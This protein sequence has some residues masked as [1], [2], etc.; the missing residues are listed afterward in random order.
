MKNLFI[1]IAAILVFVPVT[2]AQVWTKDHTGIQHST[3]EAIAKF[4]FIRT[5][6]ALP[7]TY[8][9][10]LEIDGTRL[11]IRATQSD[12]AGSYLMTIESLSQGE[13]LTIESDFEVEQR[14]SFGGD[15]VSWTYQELESSFNSIQDY[16]PSVR[17]AA[18]MLLEDVS[19]KFQA[20]LRELAELGCYHSGEFNP[21]TVLLNVFFDDLD[22]DDPIEKHSITSQ[23]V[24]NFDPL[25][26][27]PTAFELEFGLAYFE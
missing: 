21:L 27:P 4:T 16:P 15:A 14:I 17:V 11:V 20:E 2:S 7:F 19:V 22:F 9:Q 8:R 12:E 1:V 6:P 3:G 25:T 5:D 24:E 26:T 13:T 18:V 23:R 10:L